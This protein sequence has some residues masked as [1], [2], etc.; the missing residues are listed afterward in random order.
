MGVG[1]V[2]SMNT[3]TYTDPAATTA[4][5]ALSRIGSDIGQLEVL[6]H[7]GANPGVVLATYTGP[8]GSQTQGGTEWSNETLALPA[9]LPASYWIEFRYTTLPVVSATFWGDLAI[10][11][12][13]HPLGSR[14]R[15]DVDGTLAGAP[16]L[17]L[18]EHS[19]PRLRRAPFGLAV[20]VG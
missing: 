11:G 9:P 7:D 4:H 8:D 2:F 17:L 3:A 6:L 13:L 5:F 19:G 18:R 16:G 12:L 15:A 1:D 14:H 10:D 20:P